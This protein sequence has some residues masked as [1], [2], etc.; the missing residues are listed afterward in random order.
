M[1]IK[2]VA[3]LAAVMI[4][5]LLIGIK[6]V[7]WHS[8]RSITLLS[9]LTDSVIDSMASLVNLI[10]IYHSLK[11]ADREYRFGYGKIE[12]LAALGQSIFIFGSA[13]FILKEATDR[14]WA[15]V[16][17]QHMDMVLLSTLPSIALTL[18]LIAIQRKAITETN[19]LAIRADHTHYQSDLFMNVG[20][21][22]VLGVGNYFHV[23]LLDPLFGAAIAFYIMI[24]AWKI[25]KDSL[26]VLMDQELPLNQRQA[27]IEIMLEHPKVSGYHLLRTRTS[28]AGEFIQAHLEMDG[29]LSLIEAHD[30][31]HEV[32]HNIRKAYPRADIILHQDPSHLDEDHRSKV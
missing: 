3:A 30:I 12:A 23:P 29:S 7:A 25:L 17:I 14:F 18:I 22:V 8:S 13:L 16:D 10:A 4:S 15:P 9:S 28:G 19:S 1:R 5:I 26:K 6:A 21:L 11:P 31:A 27:I 32:E 24:A 20:I 2:Q